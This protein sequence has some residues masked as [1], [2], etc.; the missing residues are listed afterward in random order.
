MTP[1]QSTGLVCVLT[2]ATFVSMDAVAQV[3]ECCT[4]TATASSGVVF[5]CPQGDGDLFSSNGVTITVIARDCVTGVPVPGVPASDIWL[6]GCSDLLTLCGGSNS[7]NAT[8]PT[9][10]NGVTTIEGTIATGGCDLGGVRVIVQG[11]VVGGGTCGDPCLAI[12]VKS[13]DING[14]LQVNLVDTA[15][16]GAGYTSPPKGYNE[17]IDY[18][19]PFGTVDLAD[20]ATY[21]AHNNH[22]C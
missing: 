3:N 5:A 13:C 2:M 20:F 7:C 14:D 12:K 10:A 16:F 9:D 8:G 22:H 19:A 1:K 15:A 21:G 6:I 18:K 11:I 4:P 17:C